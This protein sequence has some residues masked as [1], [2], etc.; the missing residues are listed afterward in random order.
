MYTPT[1]WTNGQAPALNADN[2][3]KIEQG[4]ANAHDVLAFVKRRKGITLRRSADQSIATG[5]NADIIWQVDTSAS[6][7]YSSFHNPSSNPE[8]VH[9]PW[10]GLYLATLSV[11]MAE[12]TSGLRAISIVY[13]NTPA[14]AVTEWIPTGSSFFWDSA[15]AVGLIYMDEGDWL[16]GRAYQ[17]SGDALDVKGGVGGALATY[18]GLTYLGE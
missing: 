1:D 7:D 13:R 2:L 12:S 10:D 6:P 14:I 16:V 5:T 8:R 4:I 11:S 18:F 9:A 3:N 15:C 17:T